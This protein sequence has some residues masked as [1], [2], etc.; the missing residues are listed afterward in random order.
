MKKLLAL[1]VIFGLLVGCSTQKPTAPVLKPNATG[2]PMGDGDGGDDP[3]SGGVPDYITV[4][5]NPT[6]QS[7]LPG[8]LVSM[9]LRVLDDRLGPVNWNGD[10][11]PGGFDAW[12]AYVDY[13]TT[14]LVI[15]YRVPVQTN[16]GCL[17]T[18]NCAG[19][20]GVYACGQNFTYLT[21]GP[22]TDSYNQ[23]PVTVPGGTAY[24]LTSLACYHKEVNGP[25]DIWHLSFQ[26]RP[27]AALGLTTIRARNMRF[28]NGVSYCP[29]PPDCQATINIGGSN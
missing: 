15:S 21:I 7:A 5:L 20:N 18:G 10:I 13:D 12:E 16:N 1:L 23:P 29:S 17:M 4:G 2:T 24:I 8:D 3:P 25:G 6:S 27:G 11:V 22:A 28:T 9:D 26:V 14:K 19:T